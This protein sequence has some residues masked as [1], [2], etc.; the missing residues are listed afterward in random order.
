M[1]KVFF[2]KWQHRLWDADA[3]NDQAKPF[4]SEKTP[5]K[6][7]YPNAV[8]LKQPGYEEGF[9]NTGFFHAWSC[10]LQE[11]LAIVEDDKGTVHLIPAQH[12]IFGQPINDR[13]QL[14]KE[15]ADEID[16]GSKFIIRTAD[17]NRIE[18]DKEE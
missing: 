2:N 18:L 14:I 17:G 5:D 6:Q 13:E 4:Y 3:M 12:L 1:R 16:I 8:V 10:L 11:P 7:I 9:E 15:T